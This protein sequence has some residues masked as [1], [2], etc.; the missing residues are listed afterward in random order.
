MLNGFQILVITIYSHWFRRFEVVSIKYNTN[1]DKINFI[2]RTRESINILRPGST[3]GFTLIGT[4]EH[5][6]TRLEMEWYKPGPLD[7]NGV[8]LKD[9]YIQIESHVKLGSND[10]QIQVNFDGVVNFGV[11]CNFLV[12]E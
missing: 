7:E 12:K 9:L 2:M 3:G 1:T 11:I 5:P 10:V 8:V 6:H 4:D